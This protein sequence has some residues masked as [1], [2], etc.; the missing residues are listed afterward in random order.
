MDCNQTLNPTPSSNGAPTQWSIEAGHL[1]GC[2]SSFLGTIHCNMYI[3]VLAENV[4]TINS[5]LLSHRK[6]NQP[7]QSRYTAYYY[8]FNSQS[9]CNFYRILSGQVLFLLPWYLESLHAYI[10]ID[11]TYRNSLV[12]NIQRTRHCT[13]P[14]TLRLRRE[15]GWGVTA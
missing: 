1:F 3:V 13:E 11:K 10:F 2:F 9:W 7:R 5:K 8:Y 4:P 6:T 14:T 15:E 12:H